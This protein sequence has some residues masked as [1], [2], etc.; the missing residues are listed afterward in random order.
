[1]RPWQERSCRKLQ[2]RLVE[3]GL[4]GLA[5]QPSQDDVPGSTLRA[6]EG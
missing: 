3:L 5:A 1:M 4:S 6:T 2:R